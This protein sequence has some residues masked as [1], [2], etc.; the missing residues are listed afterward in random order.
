MKRRNLLTPGLWLIGITLILAAHGIVLYYASA[1]LALSATV[2]AG[3]AVLVIGKHLGL[4]GA[5]H[6]LMRRL[7]RHGASDGG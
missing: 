4:L 2:A 1:H 7:Y 5:L 6:G 3:L